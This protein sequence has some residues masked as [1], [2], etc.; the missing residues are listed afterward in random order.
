MYRVGSF[1]YSRQI[2]DKF[3]KPFSAGT[4][5]A[6]FAKFDI[7]KSLEQIIVPGDEFSCQINGAVGDRKLI[8]DFFI[9]LTSGFDIKA[10]HVP[11]G[12]NESTQSVEGVLRLAHARP[13]V[14]WQPTNKEVRLPFKMRIEGDL[15][16]ATH[17][18]LTMPLSQKLVSLI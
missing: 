18:A 13:F 16:L 10:V 12:L 9:V 17:I 5:G 2:I 8:E 6:D 14:S 4:A 1:R 3:W 15:D 11:N 7:D